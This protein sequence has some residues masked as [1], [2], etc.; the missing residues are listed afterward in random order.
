VLFH[1][2][3]RNSS[4]TLTSHT[5]TFSTASLLLAASILYREE[6]LWGREREGGRNASLSP[7]SLA[8]SGGSSNLVAQGCSLRLCSLCSGG[9][10]WG[11]GK[12]EGK[13]RGEGEREKG[14][15]GRRRRGRRGRGRRMVSEGDEG[16]WGEGRWW[17]GTQGRGGGKPYHS[18]SQ[19]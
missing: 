17:G 11:R 9:G 8:S 5:L 6:V 1:N 19:I 4:H 7:L 16:K 2:L 3:T 15:E 10:G 12:E 18:Y 13:K 14:K